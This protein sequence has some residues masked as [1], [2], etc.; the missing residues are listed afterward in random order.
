MTSTDER[1]SRTSTRRNT[2]RIAAATPTSRPVSGSSS[3]NTSGCE[4]AD[5]AGFPAGDVALLQRGTCPF[6][7]KAANAQAAGAS[8]VVIFNE[9]QPGRD[10]LVNG[11]LGGPVVTIPVVGTTYAV[12]AALAATPSTVRVAVDARPPVL[13]DVTTAAVAELD[14]VPGRQVWASVKATEVHADP[15][16]R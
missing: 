12:G 7:T 13:A 15:A 10:G 14:L 5:F 11:T 1:P 2:A 6:G 16:S 8:A 3:S 4:A 9:G